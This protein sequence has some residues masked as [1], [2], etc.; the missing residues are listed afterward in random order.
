LAQA[1]EGIGDQQGITVETVAAAG[2]P[3]D[4]L[5]EQSAGATLLVVGTRGRGGFAGLVLGSVSQSVALRSTASLVIV[6][7]RPSDHE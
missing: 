5:A 4:V 6:R 1:L 3:P 2:H 7:S